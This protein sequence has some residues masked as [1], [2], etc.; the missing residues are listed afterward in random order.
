MRWPSTV[1]FAVNITGELTTGDY[2]NDIAKSDIKN[3]VI[4]TNVTSIGDYAFQACNALESITI[5]DTVTNIS[6]FSFYQCSSLEPI[7]IPDSVTSIYKSSNSSYLPFN[8]CNL[9]EVYIS[10]ST[11]EKLD[12]KFGNNQ[13]FY[14]N[15]M[16][17]S[18]QILLLAC[19][20]AW[21]YCGLNALLTPFSTP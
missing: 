8:G 18:L 9:I 3:V 10:A 21:I 13:P 19:H 7:I 11:A 12:L 4:G 17:D 2:T 14:G 6:T 5:P 1:W 16:N 15:N 20:A